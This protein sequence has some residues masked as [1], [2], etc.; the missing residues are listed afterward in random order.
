MSETRPPGLSIIDD[1]NRAFVTEW[2]RDRS[3]FYTWFSSLITGSFVLLTVFGNKPDDL[4]EKFTVLSK[5]CHSALTPI[6]NWLDLLIIK[7][8]ELPQNSLKSRQRKP[9]KV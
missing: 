7:C 8:C 6:P 5:R 9:V 2:L 4:M 3:A 1:K